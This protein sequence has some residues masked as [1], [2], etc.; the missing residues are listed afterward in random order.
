MM[1]DLTV[2]KFGRWV[3]NELLDLDEKTLKPKRPLE[4][5]LA[6]PTDSASTVGSVSLQDKIETATAIRGMAG[7]GLRRGTS[8]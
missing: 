7:K 3:E 8:I 5:L 6:S 1:L 4:V 2:T